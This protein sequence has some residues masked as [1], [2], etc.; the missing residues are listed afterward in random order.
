MQSHHLQ[1]LLTDPVFVNSLPISTSTISPTFENTHDKSQLLNLILLEYSPDF[2]HVSPFKG[3]FL[4][5][6]PSIWNILGFEADELV[7]KSIEEYCH[8]DLVPLMRELKESSVPDTVTG[9]RRTVDLLFRARS[10]SKGYVWVESRGRLHVELGKGREAIILN[11]RAR[12][13]M[14]RGDVC[15]AGVGVVPA[16][17]GVE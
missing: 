5:V 2:I 13:M 10:N 12:P 16:V 11:G 1:A 8:P 9:S 14:R 4:Y 17:G 3:F 7:G 15:R 6:A